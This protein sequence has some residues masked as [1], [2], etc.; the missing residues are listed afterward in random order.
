VAG[1]VMSRVVSKQYRQYSY[2][3]PFFEGKRP[4]AATYRS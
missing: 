1:I 2:G 3:D 4:A